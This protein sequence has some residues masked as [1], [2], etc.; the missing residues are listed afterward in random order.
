MAKFIEAHNTI[1]NIEEIARVDFISDDI[2]LGYFPKDE[3]GNILVDFMDFVFAKIHLFSG[4]IIELSIDLYPPEE[5]ENDEDWYKRNR[6]YINLQWTSLTKALGEI[7][8]VTG[9][10]YEDIV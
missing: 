6:N 9:I 2:Y 10:E 4:D 3:D 1:I 8:E 5:Y 7:T